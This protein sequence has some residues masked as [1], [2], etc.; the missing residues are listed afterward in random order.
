ME[1]LYSLLN[2]KQSAGIRQIRK[3]YIE[4]FNRLNLRLEEEFR[5][6]RQAY[7]VLSDVGL[8]KEYDKLCKDQWLADQYHDLQEK[9]VSEPDIV[10]KAM[11][12]RG[13]YFAGNVLFEDLYADS[14]FYNGNYQKAFVAYQGI[15]SKI[16]E[17]SLLI[18]KMASACIER[19]WHLKAEDIIKLAIAKDE[20]DII[21]WLRLAQIYLIDR[22]FQ[23]YL[24]VINKAI[25]I[26]KKQK[27]CQLA[28]LKCKMLLFD[29]FDKFDNLENCTEA[30]LAEAEKWQLEN[31]TGLL[32]KKCALENIET[33]FKK[34]ASIYAKA[35]KQL[36]PDDEEI[37]QV[38]DN[39]DFFRKA[40]KY[41]EKLKND[42]YFDAIWYEFFEM[43][44]KKCDEEYCGHCQ[45]NLAR[46]EYYFY[47]A[48]D[49]ITR[50][51]R[52][53]KREYP[54]LYK[55]YDEF[56]D[57]LSDPAQQDALGYDIYL[58]IKYLMEEFPEQFEDDEIRMFSENALEDLSAQDS[59]RQEPK[60]RDEGKVGRND[61]CP[62]GSGIKYK[63]C[64]GR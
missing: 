12:K 21:S 29:Y 14:L 48:D 43:L 5:L 18:C 27:L 8:R 4:Q 51:L 11:K 58:K 7:T 33:G 45:V 2:C 13:I 17:S 39:L 47:N 52:R 63:K 22:S 9:V 40:E 31:E 19:G 60:K 3:S 1:N 37:R 20:K 26:C 6:V 34:M 24:G 36:L 38:Y 23:S 10:I 49:R 16:P 61:P 28:C 50:Q 41:L 46:F 55:A 15:C 44:D 57:A 59:Y 53:L 62:C 32:L 64:C 56:F 42:S 25:S 35:A 54:I 30:M